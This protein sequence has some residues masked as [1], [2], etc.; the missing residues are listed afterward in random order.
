L[1]H[2][3]ITRVHHLGLPDARR[4]VKNLDEL[5]AHESSVHAFDKAVANRFAARKTATRRKA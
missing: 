4:L 3:H 1:A 2:I 5:L